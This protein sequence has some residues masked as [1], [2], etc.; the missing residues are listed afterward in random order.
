MFALTTDG[1]CLLTFGVTTG[2]SCY[3][4]KR[5]LGSKWKNH[6]RGRKRRVFRVDCRFICRE[7]INPMGLQCRHTFFKGFMYNDFFH[8]FSYLFLV[9]DGLSFENCIVL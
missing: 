1:K 7:H 2:G 5:I 9:L 4:N 6:L 3:R 8:L